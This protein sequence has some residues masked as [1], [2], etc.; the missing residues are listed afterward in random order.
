MT[1]IML[2][3]ADRPA[4]QALVLIMEANLSRGFSRGKLR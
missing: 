3:S 1:L 2:F 4:Y